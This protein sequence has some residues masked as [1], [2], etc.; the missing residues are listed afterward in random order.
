VEVLC[1][2]A[3]VYVAWNRPAI[4]IGRLQRYATE[5]AMKEH[6]E[7]LHPK[8][9]TGRK[10]A[11]IGAG[12][13]SLAAAGLLALEGHK[14]TIFEK[15]SIPGGLNS[16]G[17]APYKLQAG[18]ALEEVELIRSLGVEIRTGVEIAAAGN[19]ADIVQA[20]SLLKTHDAIFL[21]LGLGADARMGLTGEDGAGVHG[22]TS[23][24]ERIKSDPS[25]RL[26]GVRR[27][28]VVGGGNTAID[29][30]HELKLLGVR[31]VAML[32]RRTGAEMPGYAHEMDAARKH[33]VQLIEGR[34]PAAVIRDGAG[35]LLGLQAAVAKD[36]K[37]VPG[38]EHE[39]ACDLIAVAIGQSR[40]TELAREFEGVE[41][42]PKGR[43]GVDPKT[44][45]TGHPKV[46]A[47]GDCVNGGKEVVNA[48][49][50]AKLAV[51]DMLVELAKPALERAWGGV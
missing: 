44:G 21:G 19:G 48:V 49:A 13:A 3:C 38:S 8:P 26:E 39:L 29:A 14:A 10:I 16:L 12:P 17:I 47:G 25:F 36:G 34:V 9:P 35:K 28:L 15:K 4:A 6:G 23:L 18:D 11:L 31:E 43:I 45:R 30:A 27:A 5:T 41:I 46:W 7:L 1:A 40:A 22:A 51:A 33:G 42:D 37:P 32:Y 20:K 24:I 2:G 50:E